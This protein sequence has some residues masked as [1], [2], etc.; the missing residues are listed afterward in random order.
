MRDNLNNLLLRE[1][2]Y[3][4]AKQQSENQ[5]VCGS[6]L[7]DNDGVYQVKWGKYI[8]FYSRFYDGTW[9]IIGDSESAARSESVACPLLNDDLFVFEWAKINPPETPQNYAKFKKEWRKFK[10]AFREVYDTRM[11][12]VTLGIWIGIITQ[13]AIIYFKK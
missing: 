13:V 3:P 8:V 5:W 10:K 12:W 1:D 2:G 4:N 9:C 7:P 6:V 11:G